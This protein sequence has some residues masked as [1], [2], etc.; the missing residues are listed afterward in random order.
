MPIPDH[1]SRIPPTELDDWLRLRRAESYPVRVVAQAG[2]RFLVTLDG[3]TDVSS[4]A[5]VYYG[6]RLSHVAMLASHLKMFNAYVDEFTGTAEERERV[7]AAVR[8][9]LVKEAGR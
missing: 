5:V 1:D 4:P 7:D 8:T 9:L 6:G 2:D 3:S